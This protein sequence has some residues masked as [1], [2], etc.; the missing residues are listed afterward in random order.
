VAVG[1]DAVAA[2]SWVAATVGWEQEQ[3]GQKPALAASH[4]PLEEE[5]HLEAD[6][7]SAGAAVAAAARWGDVAASLLDP[8]LDQE[9]QGGAV[10]VGIDVIVGDPSNRPHWSRPW[11]LLYRQLNV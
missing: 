2:G 7:R 11:P 5:S 10:Q 6:H 1:K 3:G 9:E 8:H 4:N